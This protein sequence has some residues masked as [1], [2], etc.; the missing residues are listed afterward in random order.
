MNDNLTLYIVQMLGTAFLALLLARFYRSYGHS[1]LREWSLSW[2]ALCVYAAGG[3]VAFSGRRGV[4]D[5]PAA[6][7]CA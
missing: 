4:R 1:Y 6:S 3:L 5:A 2:L 7:R